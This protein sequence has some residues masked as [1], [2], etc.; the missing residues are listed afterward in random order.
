M[1]S[2]PC[3]RSSL[4]TVCDAGGAS[5]C[6]ALPAWAWAALPLPP[7]R[8]PAPSAPARAGASALA[9]PALVGPAD[10]ATV[11]TIPAFS[12]RRVGR[13]ARYEFQ[14]SAD[15][16]F[17][18]TLASFDTLNTSASVDKTLFDGDYYWRVRAV[19]ANKTAGR[20]S[21]VRTIR[22]RWPDQPQL[23][24]PAAGSEIT[25][26]TV[27]LVLRWSPTPHAVKYEVTISADPGLAGSA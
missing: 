25:Y 16:R 17:R 21:R 12:W 2:W 4:A 14:L 1:E 22:K 6:S 3:L 24:A 19:D 13:A 15:A 27:P 7:W 8:G 23:I 5:S 10:N 26:P 9:R 18:S 11:D 20:W